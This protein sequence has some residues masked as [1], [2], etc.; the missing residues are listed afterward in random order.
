VRVGI[1]VFPE[2]EVTRYRQP[3]P[4]ARIMISLAR[5]GSGYDQ[6]IW[7][8]PQHG[9]LPLCWCGELWCLAMPNHRRQQA[10]FLT[11]T[12]IRSLFARKTRNALL[13]NAAVL[14]ALRATASAWFRLAMVIASIPEVVAA[15]MVVRWMFSVRLARARNTH[16]LLRVSLAVAQRPAPRK[17]IAEKQVWSVARAFALSRDALINHGAQPL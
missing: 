1:G 11:E 10:A 9:R 17:Q 2:R 6:P 16:Q 7:A 14:A 13:V 12:P 8:S 15:A 3:I 4:S 5:N